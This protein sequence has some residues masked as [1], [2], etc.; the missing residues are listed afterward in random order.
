MDRQGYLQFQAISV[1]FIDYVLKD[2]HSK[3]ELLSSFNEVIL[4]FRRQQRTF[5]VVAHIYCVTR[6]Y[7][8]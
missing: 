1:N 7:G 2:Y 6:T 3:E 4:C 5:N 8:K